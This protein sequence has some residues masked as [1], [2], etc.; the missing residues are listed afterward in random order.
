[1]NDCDYNS[2]YNDMSYDTER[3]AYAYYWDLV[4]SD[5]NNSVKNKKYV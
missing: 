4:E 3:V 5:Y 1:M 2:G